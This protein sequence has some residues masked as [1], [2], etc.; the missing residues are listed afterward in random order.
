MADELEYVPDCQDPASRIRE[1]EEEIRSWGR[2][3]DQLIQTQK[4]LLYKIDDLEQRAKVV[5]HPTS[6][7][8][9]LDWNEQLR[10]GIKNLLR[11]CTYDKLN[12]D[13]LYR[14]KKLV[15]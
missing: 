15:R 5:V 12:E 2:T 14:L 3:N 13:A 8:N 6:L 1:L 9:L 11:V 7:K 4:S 10:S